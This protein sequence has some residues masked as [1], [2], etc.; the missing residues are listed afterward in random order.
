M[1]GTQAL[2]GVGEVNP[3]Q[4]PN[5]LLTRLFDVIQRVGQPCIVCARIPLKHPDVA[6]LLSQPLV[7]GIILESED[8]ELLA[9]FPRRL[10]F[11]TKSGGDWQLPAQVVTDMVYVGRWTD[12]GAR[13]AWL[14]WRV[15]IRRIHNASAFQSHHRRGTFWVAIEKS[16]RSLLYRLWQSTLLRKSAEKSLRVFRVDQYLFSRRLRCIEDLPLPITVA[17]SAWK[18]GKIVMVGGTLGPGG[19][20]RQLTVTLLGLFARGHRDVHF[21]HHSPMH[22]P[23][24]FFL[25]QLIEAGIPF[26]QVDQIGESNPVS[27]E[28]EAELVQRLAPLGDLGGEIA[29]YAKEFLARRPEIVHVWLDHMNVVAGLAALLVG[30]PRIVLSCRSLSPAYFTFNQP[31]MRPIYRLLAQFP[32]VTFLN[33]SDAGASDYRRWLGMASLK[34]HVIRNGFDFSSLPPPQKL[35]YLRSEYRSRLGI[36]A[37]APVV[38]VIMRISEEKRPLLWIEIARQVA[39]RIS[40]A[41]FIVIGDGPM[42]DKVVKVAQSMLPGKIHFP[43]HEKNSMSGLAAMDLILLTS[44]VEGL[45]N[46]LI[47]AQ[48]LGVLPVAINVGGVSETMM[49]GESGWLMDTDNPQTI[50]NKIVEIFSQPESLAHISAIGKTFVTEEFCSKK[51]IEKTI[52]VYAFK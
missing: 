8:R 46:V 13:V 9:A 10:G 36:P 40:K 45:P 18:Q 42:R 49:A 51:M 17:P 3:E 35:S 41:H 22:K 47:E 32:N 19:A 20:E 39:Q 5:G 31:Y 14:A 16:L 52:A 44:R 26:S 24:D 7:E 27:H 37:D 11:Y 4:A 23:N 25:P 1:N 50:A 33:N 12:F 48:A 21:L 28:V 30:V 2:N 43:G 38:G 6:A 29:A 15:G 34:I